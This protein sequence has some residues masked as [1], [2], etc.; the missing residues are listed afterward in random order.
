MPVFAA[1][2]VLLLGLSRDRSSTQTLSLNRQ[3]NTDPPLA[4]SPAAWG[5][6]GR[7][8]GQAQSAAVRTA[9]CTPSLLFTRPP[10][11]GGRPPR[12]PGDRGCPS[13]SGAS[14]SESA[15]QHPRPLLGA[16]IWVPLCPEP[17]L[18]LSTRRAGSPPSAGR[19]RTK[20]SGGPWGPATDKPRFP[21]AQ[22]WQPGVRPRGKR[23]GHGNITNC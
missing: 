1:E 8:R 19:R 18:R 10:A 21:E 5:G 7:G 15:S 14:R 11:A 13:G 16:R 22:R 2:R 23:R 20:L 6:H 12:D 3:T 17:P 9:V 4:W